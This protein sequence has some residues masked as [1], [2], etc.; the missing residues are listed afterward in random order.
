M[1]CGRW[2][3]RRH[4]RPGIETVEVWNLPVEG[5]SLLWQRVGVPR[6]ES[7]RAAGH[8]EREIGEGLAASLVP[9]LLSLQPRLGFDAL[10][11][12]G[13]LLEIE[14]F[15][16]GLR[17]EALP[18]P[19]SFSADGRWTG[20]AGAFGLLREIGFPAG[21]M[22]DVGQTAIKASAR[23][24]RIVR[25]RDFSVLPL[26]LIDASGHSTGCPTETAAAFIASA[27][28][29]LL[30]AAGPVDPAIVLALPCPLDED[31]VPGAC[32]YGW[33]GDT[34]LLP[35]VFRRVDERLPGWQAG[36]EPE[37]L[38]LNDAELAAESALCELRPPAGARLLCLTLGFGPGAALIEG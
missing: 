15:R 12:G 25:E 35:Q 1:T 8:P 13:G 17:R 31:A 7:L 36:A 28:C 20:E 9:T 16:E 3:V 10:Y 6:V 33:E 21:A 2:R 14:G 29:D 19:L 22:L 27:L 11:L 23:D 18:F 37:V 26:R 32:T 4:R 34:R 24:R 30:R 5:G 38:V